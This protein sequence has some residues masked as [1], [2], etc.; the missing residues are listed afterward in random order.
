MEPTLLHL[1][2]FNNYSIILSYKKFNR[3]SH[4]QNLKIYAVKRVANFSEE[5]RDRLK[6]VIIYEIIYLNEPFLGDM[7]RQMN[8]LVLLFNLARQS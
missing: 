4:R 3:V 2:L 5:K 8:P 6:T 7:V 1:H